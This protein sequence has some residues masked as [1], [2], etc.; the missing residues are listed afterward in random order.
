[1]GRPWRDLFLPRSATG[2]GQ[3]IATGIYNLNTFSFLR[4]RPFGL[5]ALKETSLSI[6][7]RR[8]RRNRRIRVDCIRDGPLQSLRLGAAYAYAP[9]ISEILMSSASEGLSL[10]FSM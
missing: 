9:N 5:Q 2:R 1:M 10:H 6:I 3:L 8:I 7:I 4:R